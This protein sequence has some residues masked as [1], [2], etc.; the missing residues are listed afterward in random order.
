MKKWALWAAIAAA[1]L[2][3]VSAALATFQRFR[4]YREGLEKPS[5]CAFSETVN[6]D[7]VNASSYSEFLGVPIAWWGVC[8]YAAIAGLALFAALS[9][10]DKRATVSAAWFMSC[11]GIAYSAFLAYISFFVLRVLCVECM[12][13]YLA[14]ILLFLFLFAALGIPVGSAA[15][16]VKDYALA[17][18][19]RRSNLG[20]SPAVVRHA[21][22][23]GAVFFVG[24]IAI[25]QVQ[26]KGGAGM[27]KTGLDEKVKAFSMQ[28]LSEIEI[29]PEW[30][31]W[32]NPDAAVTLV[33][34]SEYQCPFCRMAAFNVKP[35][36]N[37]FKGDI[38]YYFV[39]FPLDNS[40]NDDMERPMH[41]Y[42]CY[43]ARAAYCAEKRGDFWAFHDDLFRSQ[44]GMNEEKILGLAEKRGWDR[45]DFLGCVNSPEADESVRRDIEA[46]RKIYITGTPTLY[47]NGRKLKYWRDSKYLQA[48][49]K[50][51][52][53][54]AKKQ[55]R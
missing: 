26:A 43:A 15:R 12:A 35:Y 49:V 36:L 4:I 53:R 37:E 20:F 2:G 30:P 22:A 34:F 5:F 45:E 50:Q 47:L 33:E 54:K 9:R 10:K 18:F 42:A 6:C 8:F 40:C 17:V 14:N 51:E 41:P 25:S 46:G 29:D 23:V 28:S 7:T 32:G 44:A 24:W 3:L 1:V 38:R 27:S 39:N 19:G 11:G 48:L 52:I 21:V 16:F 55:G 13:M 31:V